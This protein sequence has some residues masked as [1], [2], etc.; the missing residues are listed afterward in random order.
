MTE[1]SGLYSFRKVSLLTNRIPS[2]D[3]FNSKKAFMHYIIYLRV[4]S[5]K[6]LCMRREQRINLSV[7]HCISIYFPRFPSTIELDKVVMATWPY[8]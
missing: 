5:G 8:I 2:Y 6:T 4:T 1:I 3:V 7:F